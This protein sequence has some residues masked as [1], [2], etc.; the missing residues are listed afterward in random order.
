MIVT[1]V[2]VYIQIRSKNAFFGFIR[3]KNKR[4]HG[5]REIHL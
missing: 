1:V 4:K 2:Q 3:R 5:K